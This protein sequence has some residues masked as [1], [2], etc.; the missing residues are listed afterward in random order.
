MNNYESAL[1]TENPA[2]NEVMESEKAPV[3]FRERR[4]EF[5]EKVMLQ[6]RKELEI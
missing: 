4:Q 1:A 2:E 6:F 5:Q 3:N